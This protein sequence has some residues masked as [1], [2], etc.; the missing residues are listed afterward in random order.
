MY[1]SPSKYVLAAPS[2][3]SAI[4]TMLPQKITPLTAFSM[5]VKVALALAACFF[6]PL[7]PP[8]AKLAGPASSLGGADFHSG[9]NGAPGLV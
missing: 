4:L 5:A 7:T 9:G 8:S 3:M 6:E 2:V 1:F